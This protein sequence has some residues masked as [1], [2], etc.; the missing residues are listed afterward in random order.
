[1][2]LFFSSSLIEQ[3]GRA[4][5][6]PML[7]GKCRAGLEIHRHHKGRSLSRTR[8]DGVVIDWTGVGRLVGALFLGINRSHLDGRHGCAQLHRCRFRERGVGQI[9]AG[10]FEE[11]TVH[12]NGV[13]GCF[14]LEFFHHRVLKVKRIH[15]HPI[16]TGKLLQKGGEESR[17]TW[18][19]ESGQPIRRWLVSIAL[20]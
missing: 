20:P 15:R 8:S 2:T 19:G 18:T 13:R 12:K 9:P 11:E 3:E 17:N 10:A 1:M 4:V 7:A 5:L 16:T 14:R 6:D